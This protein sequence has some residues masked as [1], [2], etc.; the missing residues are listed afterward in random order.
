MDTPLTALR[1]LLASEDRC[2]E[3]LTEIEELNTRR[4]QVVKRFTENALTEVNPEKGILFFRHGELEHGIIG[5]IAGKLTEAYNRPSI[6]LCESHG[7]R[8]YERNIRTQEMMKT[9]NGGSGVGT[10]H[11][12]MEEETTKTTL[13]ASCRSPEW[14]NLVEL[15]DECKDFFIRYGGH[16]QAAGFTIETAR[17]AEFE[18]YIADIFA[19]RY[20]LENLPERT[21]T[22]ES[23]LD[24]KLANLE[25]LNI[26]QQF[27]PF[28]IGNPKPLWLLE[29]V[30]I[31]EQKSL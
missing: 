28:G 15:L 18:R 19:K 26:I 29:S 4:Q 11:K 7:N 22:V 1:W 9:I 14:C 31:T 23:V 6:V 20:S 17:F 3:F 25:T 2:D 30:T 21:L 5:L 13:V 27:R 16:R 24:P 12:S 10:G 8:E